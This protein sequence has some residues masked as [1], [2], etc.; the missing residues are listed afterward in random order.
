[1]KPFRPG[2]GMRSATK[3]P[4]RMRRLMVFT[5]TPSRSAVW[6]AVSITCGCSIKRHYQPRE[7]WTIALQSAHH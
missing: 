2:A 5:D 6:F 7:V 4:V 3:R 1:M